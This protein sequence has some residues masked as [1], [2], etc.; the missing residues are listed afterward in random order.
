MYTR[1]IRWQ[2]A[3]YEHKAALIGR[4]PLEVSR[5]ADLMVEALLR[6]FEIYGADYLTVGLDVYN[7][8]AEALGANVMAAAPLACPDLTGPLF[9]LDK[10]PAT[11][12]Q[13]GIPTAGR[14]GIFLEAGLRVQAGLGD[15][16]HVRVAASGPVT[17]AA[18]LT[19]PEAIILSLCMEDGQAERLL[20]FCTQ[21]S[22]QWLRCLRS[23]NLD[24]IVFDSM[25]APPM[26]SPELYARHVLPLHQH[27]MTILRE[28]NQQERELV[29]GGNTAPI[30]RLLSST[31]AN[32]LL[33]DYATD[34]KTFKDA[35]GDDGALT[36]RRNIAPTALSQ[37]D[38]S[39]AVQQFT[40][41]LARFSHPIAGTGILPYSFE[42]EI[43]HRFRQQLEM[44]SARQCDA[45]MP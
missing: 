28:S 18:K 6:E 14:F 36:I 9:D 40:A 29:I 34:A 21:I 41:D 24:A 30:T 39:I 38:T 23:H 19:N 33:C 32:I 26:F 27:L 42:P 22:A 17:L 10:L 35:F 5:S 1:L 13:P 16:S 3:I 44:E 20:A 43:F 15:R 4:A 31:G 45:N 8:E 7:V 11:L 12:P 2:P 25:A 37:A